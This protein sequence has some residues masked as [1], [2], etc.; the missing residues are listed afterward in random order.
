MEEAK[1]KEMV[2][3]H[4]I[5]NFRGGSGRGDR[6]GSKPMD[7]W[8]G[9]GGGKGDR[10]GSKEVREKFDQTKVTGILARR[11]EKGAMAPGSLGPNTALRPGGWKKQP[12]TSTSAPVDK[13]KPA[14]SVS[15]GCG[16]SDLKTIPFRSSTTG[17]KRSGPEG[18]GSG[19]RGSASVPKR[20]HTTPEQEREAVLQ[21]V[22]QFTG[23]TTHSAPAS[24]I[25]VSKKS[26]LDDATVRR[27]IVSIIAELVNN[28]DFKV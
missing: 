6:R 20:A 23:S 16:W 8:Q 4:Q 18:R 28:A 22:S 13:S 11:K 24:A 5:I 15:G 26:M 7:E 1:E 2:Q 9:S 27:K 17:S 12:L 21:K 3:Q 19:G 14:R 25:P 10:G